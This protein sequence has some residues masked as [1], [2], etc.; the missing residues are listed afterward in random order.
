MAA[1]TSSDL[2]AQLR[3]Y[4]L[5]E[6]AYLEELERK[7][8]PQFPDPKDLAK[9]LL[10]RKWL[11]PFQVNQLFLN[12]G[13]ALLLASY[14]LLDRLGGGG[15]GDV[16]KA[17][18]WKMGTLV[19]IKII[20]KD[21]IADKAALDRFR[22]EIRA[23]AKLNHVNI[24]KAHDADEVG[25]TLLLVMEYVEGSDL[26]KLVKVNG[27]LPID[28]ACDFIRQAALGLQHAFEQG[29]VH[30]D[31]KPHNLLVT[32]SRREDA[33]PTIRKQESASGGQSSV[34]KILDM[35][36]ARLSQANEESG[37]TS[38]MT[39]E[40]AIL[41]TPDYIAPE[42]V[43]ESHTVDIRA[44]LYSLGCTFY[45]LLAGAV[46][47]PKGSLVQKLYKHQFEEPVGVETLRRRS[48]NTSAPSCAS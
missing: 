18:N 14:I 30:R 7:L 28:Q 20:R 12:R 29:M 47:F 43:R 42:Q 34:I 35:G 46:P 25:G 15:M 1:A 24:V 16:F 27:P 19:A 39:Q 9:E 13:K 38:S 5:L 23:A 26:A 17:R 2:V 44:D 31:I 40:G 8:V 36:L 41:G 32:K 4:R 48:Q 22:R 45:F 3:Q 33:G 11:S 37:S 21:R 6:P 10:K